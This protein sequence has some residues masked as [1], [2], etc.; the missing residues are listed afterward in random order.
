MKIAFHREGFLGY[1][2]TK[3]QTCK[4]YLAFYIKSKSG[5]LGQPSFVYAYAI[6]VCVKEPNPFPLLPQV[7][8]LQ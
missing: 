3:F 6:Y 4:Y 5:L 2:V 7:T 1:K 8:N